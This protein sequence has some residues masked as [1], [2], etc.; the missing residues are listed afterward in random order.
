MLLADTAGKVVAAA[1]V[2]WKGALGGIIE[3]T[4][5]SMAALDAPAER[6]VACVGPAIQQ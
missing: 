6:V 3:A 4:V 2:G 5:A 1:H